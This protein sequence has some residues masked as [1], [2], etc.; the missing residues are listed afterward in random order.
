M[1]RIP[2]IIM[3]LESRTL[4]KPVTRD[5]MAGVE[6]VMAAAVVVVREA[7]GSRR[8][9]RVLPLRSLAC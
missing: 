3:I 7:A 8:L 6:G 2:P 1:R 5:A 9:G 4:M